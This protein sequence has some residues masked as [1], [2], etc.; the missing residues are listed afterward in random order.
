MYS[1]RRVSLSEL[2]CGDGMGLLAVRLYQRTADVYTEPS[3][4]SCQLD[5]QRYDHSAALRTKHHHN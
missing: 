1:Q 4:L 5:P 3:M 2:T